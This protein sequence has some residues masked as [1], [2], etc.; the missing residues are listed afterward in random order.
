LVVNI[1]VNIL[2]W[3]SFGIPTPVSM[4]FKTIRSDCLLASIVNLP[5]FGIA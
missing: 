3:I 5:P 2:L 1:T 4:T